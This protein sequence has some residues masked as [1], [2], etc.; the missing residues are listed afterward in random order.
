MAEQAWF[1][2]G[3][4]FKEVMAGEAMEEFRRVCPDKIYERGAY[5]FHQGERATQ[6]HVIASGQVKLVVPTAAGHERVISVVGPEDMIG[7]AFVLDEPRYRVDAIA[8]TPVQTCPMNHAQFTR[9]ALHSP[10]FVLRFATILATS[11]IGCREVLSHTFDP[12][13]VRIAKVLLDQAERFGESDGGSGRVVSLTTGLRHDE[14]ASMASATRV[15]ASMAIA[16]LREIGLVEGS[17]GRYR[18]D[19]DGLAEYV[20][21][22]LF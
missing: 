9:L 8:L 13:K 7:E 4:R 14:I 2:K 10:E 12:V 3:T 19:I 6:L 17:R 16:Q 20:E 1:A 18:I 15:S 22:S 11:L 21:E 5:L